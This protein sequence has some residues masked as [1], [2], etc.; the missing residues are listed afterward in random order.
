MKNKNIIE[1]G[2]AILANIA[3]LS[4]LTLKDLLIPTFFS[5]LTL[6]KFFRKMSIPIANND[7]IMTVIYAVI[8]FYVLARLALLSRTIKNI[9]SEL[10]QKKQLEEQVKKL[11]GSNIELSTELQ[12]V[13]NTSK[14]LLGNLLRLDYRIINIYNKFQQSLKEIENEEKE[15]VKKSLFTIKG[16]KTDSIHD[17]IKEIYPNEPNRNF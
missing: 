11:E 3:Q 14:F 12:K 10:Q 17:L 16:I 1:K 13:K 7:M 15:Y 6:I 2:I 9:N 5:F 8:I 4:G